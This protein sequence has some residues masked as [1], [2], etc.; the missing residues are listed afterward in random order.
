MMQG[1]LIH[2][3]KTKIWPQV[4]ISDHF[5]RAAIGAGIL[6]IICL[7]AGQALL[8]RASFF[9]SWALA[10]AGFC[11]WLIKHAINLW[12]FEISRALLAWLHAAMLLGAYL[13]SRWCVALTLGLPAKDFDGAVAVMTILCACLV[14]LAMILLGCM[15]VAVGCLILAPVLESAWLI[16]TFPK[17]ERLRQYLSMKLGIRFFK[18]PSLMH[19]PSGLN[20]LAHLYGGLCVIFALVESVQP[21]L[22]LSINNA[23]LTR[24]VAYY[25]DYHFQERYPGITPGQRFILHDNNVISV[26]REVDSKIEIAVGV[27]DPLKGITS[28]SPYR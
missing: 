12:K 5:Y 7:F 20:L 24:R 16:S 18:Q 21:I 3:L 22:D 4:P 10:C 11:T 17:G 9:L 26:A 1:T 6:A 13:L 14:Y 27:I 2:R 28:L 25:A 8:S 19:K 15:A 23:Q